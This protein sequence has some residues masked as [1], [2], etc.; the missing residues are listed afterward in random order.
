MGSKPK[1]ERS[2]DP[3]YRFCYK[4]ILINF[5]E[6]VKMFGH[7]RLDSCLG[8]EQDSG[9]EFSQETVGEAHDDCAEEYFGV[10]KH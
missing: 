8:L 5:F 9:N 2:R 6:I 10:R 4:K 3:E 7:V 1:G